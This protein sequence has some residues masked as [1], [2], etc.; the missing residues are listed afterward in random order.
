M[1]TFLAY[2]LIGLVDSAIYAI[3]ASGLVLT[4][5]TSGV[6]NFAHGA[7]GMLQA[8]VFWELRIGLGLPV[9]L[10][11]LI[12]LFL[13]APL[14]GVLLES[15]IMRW[16]AGA[17]L[18][19]KLVVTVALFVSF[20][21]LAQAIWGV[22]IRTLPPLWGPH[23]YRVGGL[24]V[25]WDQT[26]VV[27][28][29]V[30]VALALWALLKLTRLGVAM[31]A[32]VD[33]P[34]LCRVKGINPNRVTKASWSLGSMLAGL[35]A[36]LIAPGLNLDPNVLSS[37]VVAAFAAAI[38]GRLQSLPATFAGAL[39]L[40]VGSDMV[41]GYFAGSGTL[42]NQLQPALPFVLLFG[43]LLMRRPAR[44]AEKTK[45]PPEPRPPDRTRALGWSGVGLAVA[46]AATLVI[47]G[48][49]LLIGSKGL[50]YA[51]TLMSLLLLTGLSGQVSLMQFSF[52]GVG[53]VV[54][55]AL[56]AGVPFLVGMVV[57]AAVAALV[58][59]LVALPAA[60]LQGI[61]LALGTLAFAIL[62]DSL[63][64]GND[65][66]LGGGKTLAVRRPSFLGV[67]MTSEKNMFIFSAVVAL[68]MANVVLA[69]RRG[70]FGRKL[71]ALRDSPIASETQG[72]NLMKIRLQVFG[73][74]AAVAGVAGVLLGSVQT[75]VGGM[76]FV[77][78]NSLLLLLTAAAYGITRVSGAFA[79]AFFLT[80]LPSVVTNW[81]FDVLKS[82][83]PGFFDRATAGPNWIQPVLIGSLAIV[84]AR[85]PEGIVGMTVNQT[86]GLWKTVTSRRAA[87]PGRLARAPATIGAP[88]LGAVDPAVGAR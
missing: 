68:V 53:A 63:F 51:I 4:Y 81:L 79:G 15:T 7:V 67:S 31:R 77:Y 82:V 41:I 57:A 60:R 85:H 86:R 24:V 48:Y 23:F 80:V 83:L 50:A 78:Q 58:G 43:A 32:V 44:L 20:Q 42:A 61:Y 62:L 2:L 76:N 28:A 75:R 59:M 9:W 8:F 40:G 35:A 65:H 52:A 64:F 27:V 1:H 39:I 30:L 34:E 38:W 22:Q 25:S 36:I 70:T 72:M 55:S 46:A 10:A 3:S 74:S 66:I 13:V 21:G 56:P 19:T 29:A 18:A 11:L 45:V 5:V 47:P 73:V 87:L 12:T 17:S 6:F 54:F 14:L 16:L 33:N 84:M 37:L 88:G 69:L 26:T 49:Q 71:A